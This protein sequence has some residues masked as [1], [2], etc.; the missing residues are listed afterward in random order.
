M[1]EKFQRLVELLLEKSIPSFVF[2]GTV[3]EIAENK[4]YC[5]ITREDKP[6]LFKVRL[7]AIIG[8]LENNITSIPKIGSRVLCS[9]IENNATEA[10][11]LAC[12]CPEELNIKF[13]ESTLI[14]N[15]D[16]I[17]INGGKLGGIIIVDKLVKQL[18]VLSKRVDGIINAIKNGKPAS[19]SMDG[20]TMYQTT[21][22]AELE[23]ITETENFSDIVNEKIKH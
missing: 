3:K 21:M 22:L 4:Q 19:G 15:Q 20:G 6:T 2:L 11:V 12:E 10:F 5:T 18:G 8:E 14:I 9:L 16:N 7:N 23:K 1:E 13:G 17:L